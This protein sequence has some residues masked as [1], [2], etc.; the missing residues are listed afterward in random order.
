MGRVGVGS[1]CGSFSAA[2]SGKKNEHSLK[3]F[4]SSVFNPHLLT[5]SSLLL[6]VAIAAQGR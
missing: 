3:P 5:S 2:E 6:Q 4:P 1:H